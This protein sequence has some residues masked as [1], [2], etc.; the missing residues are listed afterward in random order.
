MRHNS[1]T[2]AARTTAFAFLGTT[3][4]ACVAT[5][6]HIPVSTLT[7]WRLKA[8]IAPYRLHRRTERYFDLLRQY[9]EGLMAQQIATAI[10]VTR[11]AAFLMLHILA[12]RG[13]VKCVT[14]PNSRRYGGRAHRLL[15]RLPTQK[16]AH[17]APTD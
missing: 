16:G 7:R 13:A 4:D 17:H 12:R 1:Y 5:Q 6:M 14:I 10:G 11:Q 8:K 2:T 3:P 9:P 15:W